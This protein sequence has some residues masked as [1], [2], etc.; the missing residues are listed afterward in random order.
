ME[1]VIERCAGL[2]VHKATVAA[3]VRTPGTG[4]IRRQEVR[5]F[6]TTTADLL[7]LRDWL[8]AHGVTHVAMEAT[9]VFWK[10]VYY[11]L[12]DEFEL[13]LVNAAH[14]KQVPGRKTD[15][16]DCAWLAQLLEHGLLRSSLVP[17]RPIRDLRDLH[18]ATQ[19][20]DPGAHPGS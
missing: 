16:A 7:A 4:R 14:V 1:Q 5:T 12:E 3:C 18:P 10:P 17:P 9:G 6:G 11:V 13:L 8:C 15:V 2:D 19:E 20:P